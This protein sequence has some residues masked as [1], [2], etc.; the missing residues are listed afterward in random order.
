M[1][2]IT[3]AVNPDHL[4]KAVVI[5]FLYCKI[6]LF[7]PFPCYT[8]WKKVTMH[9]V[10]LS[11]ELCYISLRVST[12]LNYLIFFCMEDLSI[13]L[14]LFIYS[15]KQSFIYIR[16][17]LWIFI[18]CFGLLSNATLFLLKIFQVWLLISLSVDSCNPLIYPIIWGFCL[19]FVHLLTFWSYKMLQ[20]HL[21]Y[22]LPHS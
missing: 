6:T 14:H 11:G 3:V 13:L 16:K 7:S 18:L 12:Y 5:R 20:A 4:A 21:A 15:I 22:F 10:D 1:W 8:L 19:C 2:L 17:D 9:S